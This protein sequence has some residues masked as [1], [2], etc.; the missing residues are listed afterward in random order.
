MV[1]VLRILILV[2]VAYAAACLAAAVVGGAV[3]FGGQAP[4]ASLLSLFLVA[5]VLVGAWSAGMVALLPAVIGAV[6]AEIGGWR[7]W[8]FW[9]PFGMV[10]ALFL[11][12]PGVGLY[13][14][15]LAS[16]HVIPTEPGAVLENA[17][18]ADLLAVAALCGAVAGL[19]YWAIAGRYSGTGWGV[20]SSGSGPA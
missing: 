7:S 8:L 1:A 2:P 15:I 19:V 18:R 14:G 6:A 12:V 4:D 10:L 20:T 17:P 11:C 5:T 3:V 9:V 16:V 13:A